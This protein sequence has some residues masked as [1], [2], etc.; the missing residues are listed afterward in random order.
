MYKPTVLSLT[1]SQ[2]FS[3]NNE[4]PEVGISLVLL[5]LCKETNHLASFKVKMERK[6]ICS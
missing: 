1:N 6:T 5:D 4:V 2:K 3:A